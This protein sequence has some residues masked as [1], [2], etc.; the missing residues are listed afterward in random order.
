MSWTML[1]KKKSDTKV[2]LKEWIAVHEN[3]VGRKIK[4]V[5][6]DSRGEYVD[7]SFETWLKEHGIQY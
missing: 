2:S 4:A 5:R 7:A 1:S 3:E 6:S